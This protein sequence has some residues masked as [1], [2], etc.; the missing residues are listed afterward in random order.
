MRQ[1]EEETSY[2]SLRQ[3]LP[4]G[5]FAAVEVG[6]QQPAPR[7]SVIEENKRSSLAAWLLDNPLQYF[8]PPRLAGLLLLF[9]GAL[10][11][12]ITR[13]ERCVLACASHNPAYGCSDPKHAR[14]C[15]SSHIDPLNTKHDS[16]CG[17][18][19]RQPAFA[20]AE[21][22][23]LCLHLLLSFLYLAAHAAEVDPPAVWVCAYFGCTAQS[24]GSE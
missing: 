8:A 4:E 12:W 15:E 24:S 22:T 1:D 7:L 5:S 23:C 14:G 2:T 13:A 10:L 19:R 18:V 3:R 9:V 17:H 20:A 11:L 21:Q 6:Q 16:T